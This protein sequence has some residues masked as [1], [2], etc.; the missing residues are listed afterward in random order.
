MRTR[1]QHETLLTHPFRIVI[2]N[3]I[4]ITVQ[5]W[6]EKLITLATIRV[7]VGLSLFLTL[8]HDLIVT[9]RPVDFF[10]DKP[11][12]IILQAHGEYKSV[13]ATLTIYHQSEVNHDWTMSQCLRIGQKRGSSGLQPFVS[14]ILWSA[15]N[16]Q[17][18]AKTSWRWLVH[19]AEMAIYT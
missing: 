13:C 11:A 3:S 8:S 15:R 19:R 5:I 9:V 14:C 12:I 18:M 7:C 4:I 1:I 6:N 2:E 10:M 17:T 16:N